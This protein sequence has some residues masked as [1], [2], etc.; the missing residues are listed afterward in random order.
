MSVFDLTDK[1]VFITGAGRG[2]GRGIASVLAGAGANVAINALT[3]TH[4]ES[5]AQDIED[6]TGKKIVT[7]LG[8]VTTA[9]GVSEVVGQVMSALGHIDILINNLGDAVGGP[10]AG[11]PDKQIDPISDA[12]LK[13]TIDLNMTATLLCTREVGPQ[14]LARR[15]GKVINISSYTAGRAGGNV[16]LYS[17]AKAAVTGFTRAQALEWA[18]YGVNVNSIA[19]G[20]YPEPAA[21]TAERA[22]KLAGWAKKA[23]PLGRTGAL[24]EVGYLALYLASSAS[25]YMT[26]QTLYLDG[27]L[28][29]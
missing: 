4:A 16:V 5:T 2:I 28:S 6:S 23:I 12:D 15:S 18:P 20:L 22:E 24:E 25:D 26:G 19:P 9:E 1:T 17:A 10:L 27:G 13:K 3:S 7:A 8:D 14:M 29:L 11:L 21:M